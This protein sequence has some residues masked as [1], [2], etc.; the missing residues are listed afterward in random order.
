[1]KT[2][3]QSELDQ[4]IQN[5]CSQKEFTKPLML[6]FA[7]GYTYDRVRHNSLEEDAHTLWFSGHP[8]RG[9][10][11]VI[12]DGKAESLERHP[13]LLADKIPPMCYTDQVERLV[14]HR[15][16][17]S[18]EKDIM[19]YCKSQIAYLQKP[20]ICLILDSASK[21]QESVDQE[22]LTKYFEQYYVLERTYDEWREW[23]MQTY[24]VKNQSGVEFIHTNIVPELVEYMDSHK[25]LYVESPALENMPHEGVHT[26][27][28]DLKSFSDAINRVKHNKKTSIEET[29]KELLYYCGGDNDFYR[30][31]G[32]EIQ[33]AQDLR[34]MLEK[35]FA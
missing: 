32:S 25:D 18:L 5:Y 2:V 19:D 7:S 3:K 29:I 23:A 15:M 35:V 34:K 14:Y 9:C 1:M 16:D 21:R 13:E 30:L 26:R 20:V 27:E 6:W 8:M 10:D 33:E 12:I 24:V 4:L 22:Y 11:H 17:S 31:L 28:Y